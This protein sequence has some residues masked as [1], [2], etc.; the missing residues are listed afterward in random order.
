MTKKVRAVQGGTSASK[1]ISILMYLIHLA[2]ADKISTLTSVTAESTPHLKRGALRDFQNIMKGHNYWKEDEW[3]ATDKIYT[4]K[5]TGSQIE[6]FSA[7]QPEKLRGGRR[8]RGFMNEANNMTLEQFDEFEVRT[9][10]FVYLDWNPTIDFWFYT[11][12]EPNRSD[13]ERI[14]INYLDNEALDQ[15]T[16]NSIEQRKNRKQ[17]WQV[18]GLGLLGETEE[19]IYTGWNIIES[20]PHEAKLVRYWIDF[21]YSNDPTSIGAVY[22]Y[23]NGYILDELTYQKGLLNKQ[24]ADVILNQEQKALVIADCAEPKSIDE[25]KQYGITILP[26]EKG[27]DSIRNGIAVVQDQRISITQRSVD[28][29]KEYRNYVWIKDK[30][31]RILNEASDIWNHSMDGLRYAITSL[32]HGKPTTLVI[33]RPSYSGY[34]R[35]G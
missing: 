3:N 27:P 33:N 13:T 8:D 34:N 7:D 24:I 19:R 20:I 28:T 32:K 15:S 22:E 25:I 5:K 9:R 4:F 16:V 1:T 12:I 2:Q 23:N 35:R 31:G 11:D 29:I 6:F 21:G 17:W 10:E 26:A 30:D 14:V 18:Y